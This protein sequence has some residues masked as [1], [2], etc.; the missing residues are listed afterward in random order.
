MRPSRLEIVAERQ[1]SVPLGGWQNRSSGAYGGEPFLVAPGLGES[2]TSTSRS[3]Q[4]RS[5][6]P[7]TRRFAGSPASYWRIVLAARQVRLVPRLSEGKLRLPS[8][9]DGGVLALRHRPERG[10]DPERG[11][12]PQHLGG[13]G[14][15]DAHAAAGDPGPNE[16]QGAVPWLIC[17]PRQA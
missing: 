14:R 11:E 7:A 13:D 4:R 6:S 17:A 12:Q 15:I 2:G 9:L 16:M 10:L 8:R 1:Q 5:S 3:F